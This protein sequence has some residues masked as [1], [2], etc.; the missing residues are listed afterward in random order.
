MKIID[1][2]SGT[3][4]TR[5]RTNIRQLTKTLEQLERDIQTKNYLKKKNGNSLHVPKR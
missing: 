2:K 3:K 4:S 5:E 1:E